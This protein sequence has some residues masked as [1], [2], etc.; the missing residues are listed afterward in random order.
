MN[1]KLKYY[2]SLFL[3]SLRFKKNITKNSLF[4]YIYI[5]IVSNSFL[6]DD[7]NEILD[8]L[9]I[10]SKVGTVNTYQMEDA[11]EFLNSQDY[12]SLDSFKINICDKLVTECSKNKGRSKKFKDDLKSVSYFV[13]MISSY[14][15]EI[16]LSIFF[17]EPNIEDAL[18]RNK[19]KISL[20][21]NQ[22]YKLLENFQKRAKSSNV[23]L[24]KYD[25][26]IAW[27]DYIFEE[28]LKGK[29][30]NA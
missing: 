15:D 24:D 6:N 27:L 16:I 17:N 3:Y 5:F 25:V 4:R 22:L 19:T 10:D 1:Q 11:L 12:I 14:S 23:D 30:I 28:Y 8:E 2:M 13:N 21:N 18:S 20:N 9:I 7:E 26:F 29:E